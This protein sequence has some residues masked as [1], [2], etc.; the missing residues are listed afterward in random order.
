MVNQVAC[1]AF[2]GKSFFRTNNSEAHLFGLEPHYGCCTANL[3]QGW[4]KLTL[5]ALQKTEAGAVVA[6][7]LP[8][9]VNTQFSGKPVS[10]CVSS[11]YPFRMHAEITLSAPEPVSFELAI[12]IP[13]WAKDVRINQKRVSIRQGHVYLSQCWQGETTL[14]L[15]M[16]DSVHLLSRPHHLRAVQYGPLIFS[17]PIQTEHRMKEY[18][19]NGVERKHPYCD[20]EL[21]PQ[22]KWNY[23]FAQKDLRVTENPIDA[24]PFS[25]SNPPLEIRTLMAE[26]P[27][28]WADGY[29]SVP[30]AFPASNKA[31]S[32][33]QPMRLIPYGCAKL[34]MTEMPLS[35]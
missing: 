33:A 10:I 4:P 19:E 6:H 20:Y 7:L 28:N 8:V 24:V 14:K 25:S 5:S 18:T 11:D 15:T 27:W 21:I 9:Q 26:V 29:D 16:T 17:L 32:P 22:S 34:R 12:R 23:G 2:P 35:K 1:I 30:E 3:S 31:I 13:G